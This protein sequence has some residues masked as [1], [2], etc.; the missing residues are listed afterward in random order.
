MSGFAVLVYKAHPRLLIFPAVKKVRR[1][2]ETIRYVDDEFLISGN[3]LKSGISVDDEFGSRTTPHR[4]K[5]KPSYCPP[6]RLLSLGQLQ[7]SKST[8]QDRY[9]YALY[10]GEIVLVGSCLDTNEFLTSQACCCA[11]WHRS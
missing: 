6:G 2:H 10:G 4:I 11:C 1:I 8:H 3:F 5:A 9:M 7:I